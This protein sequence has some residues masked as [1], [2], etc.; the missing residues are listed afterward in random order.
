M[1]SVKALSS[2]TPLPLQVTGALPPFPPCIY[3]L[4]T[5]A[6]LFWFLVCIGLVHELQMKEKT[7]AIKAQKRFRGTLKP[8]P[9]LDLPNSLCNICQLNKGVMLSCYILS[10]CNIPL[11]NFWPTDFPTYCN[12]GPTPAVYF[13]IIWGLG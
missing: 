11:L 2:A 10:K 13:C 4:E 6:V 8:I 9:T 3:T 5:H 1:K 7:R 12:I